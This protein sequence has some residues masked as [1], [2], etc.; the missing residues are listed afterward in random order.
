MV[1]VFLILRSFNLHNGILC[2]A[3]YMVI[4]H[5]VHVY[6]YNSGFLYLGSEASAL[7]TL[8]RWEN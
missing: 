3:S 4:K 7:K 5:A 6:F 2:R 1:M 8:I